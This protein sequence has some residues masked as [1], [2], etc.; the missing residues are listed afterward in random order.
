[1]SEEDRAPDETP[2]PRKNNPRQDGNSR[3]SAYGHGKRQ[4]VESAN[5]LTDS[6]RL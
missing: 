3:E 2:K 5:P 6:S 1:M 4:S